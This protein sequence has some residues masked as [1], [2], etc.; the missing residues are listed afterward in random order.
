MLI[1]RARATSTARCCSSR[2]TAASSRRSRTACSSSTA[3]GPRVYGGGY[4]RVRRGERPRGAGDASP[5][6]REHP[7][8]STTAP[9]R[10]RAV[11]VGVQ[12]PGVTDAELDVVARR[13]RAARQDARPRGRRRASRSGATRL[14]PAA[15]V[16][17]GKLKEL[18]ALHRRQR[19]GAGRAPPREA[20]AQDATTEREEA[21]PPTPEPGDAPR[22]TRRAR[23]PRRSRP[24][25]ARNLERATG[26]EVLD[27]TAVILAI[28]QR[29][30]RSREARLQ[31]EIARLSYV[32]P[33]L[34]E[35]GGG[36]D[37]QGGGIGGTG[38]GESAARARPAQGPR[39]HRRAARA[40]SPRS[41]ASRGTRRRA[42]R[43][44]PHR[45]ARRLHERRQ[46]VAD[47]RAHRQRRARRRQALRHA[48]HH[49]ARA[50][51]RD[52]A[53]HPRL[54]HGRLHQE[55]A[56]RPGR[57]ASARRSTRR[58]TRTCCCT[59][60]TRPTP[61]FPA[62][63]EVTREVLGRDR[64]R[65]ERRACWCSTRSTGSTPTTRARSRADWPDALLLS[66][67]DPADVAALRER[68]VAFFE[69]DMVEEELLVPYAQQRVVAEAHAT[70]HVLAES[71]DE[72]GTRLRVRAAPE[73]LARLRSLLGEGQKRGRSTRVKK[74]R[75]EF[76]TFV[77]RPRFATRAPRRSAR[78]TAPGSCAGRRR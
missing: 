66:S 10:P 65:R 4:A 71:H 18:A 44:Q 30:A 11:L 74:L 54:R 12:L 68:I 2:T 36:G 56:A 9:P 23:R 47:A 37:R 38:A 6:S 13:A 46:V 70:T 45:R 5:M 27:R 15:V 64:R 20:A 50:P 67:R 35:T 17:E 61:R 43:A 39:P 53:A 40:S 72:H 21:A 76:F 49:G 19:R 78:C 48:R 7:S 75:D 41:S 32:A 26:A 8:T 51:A 31:V 33:R 14:A 59:W 1:A 52:H 28:F 57:V 16:G 63:I 62:Q 29:H 24:S 22:A 42:P 73:A 58:A 3:G 77:Q 25:Q 69:R 60:R 34:R 55:A